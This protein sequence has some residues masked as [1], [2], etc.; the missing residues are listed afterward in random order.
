VLEAEPVTGRT[1]QIRVHL[2]HIGYPVVGD[3]VYGLDDDLKD[4]AAREGLTERVRRALVMD[5]QA[6]HC[7]SLEFSHPITAAPMLVEAPI[8]PDMKW[9]WE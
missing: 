5:R 8:P 3:K 6:L 2:A 4:E 7:R 1:N 9:A